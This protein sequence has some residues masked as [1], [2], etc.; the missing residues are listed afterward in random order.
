DVDVV[1]AGGGP[2]GLL[3]ASELRLGGAEPVVL[4]RLPAPTGLSKALVLVGR[5][6]QALDY[7]GL[8]ERLGAGSVP[9]AAYSRFAHLGGI[10]LE[11]SGLIDAAPPGYFPAPVPARQAQVEAGGGGGGPE[12][13]RRRAARPRARRAVS[14]PGCGHRGGP[15]PAGEL[16]AAR[17]VS[18]RL[19][20]RP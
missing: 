9:A 15:G 1:V 8:L 2:A 11:V 12:A 5:V 16:P 3:L 6:V 13:R 18:G 4:E 10:P 17:P 14:G 7:R 20:R 19:R